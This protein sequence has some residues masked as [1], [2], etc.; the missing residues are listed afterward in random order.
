MDPT[1]HSNT[2]VVNIDMHYE[3]SPS[4]IGRS[5]T[6]GPYSIAMLIPRGYIHD[7]L[8]LFIFI[9]QVLHGAGMFTY[10]FGLNVGKCSIH[11]SY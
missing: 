10:M 4:L 2:Y 6:D 11:G 7:Y 3:K 1:Y 8:L 5:T 9:Y